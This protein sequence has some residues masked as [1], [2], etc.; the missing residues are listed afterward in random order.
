MGVLK[1]GA[2]KREITP[3]LGTDLFGYIRRF[4]SSSGVHDPLWASFL[5]VENGGRAV[6]LISLDVL[7]FSE[8]FATQAKAA[9]SEG[10]DVAKENI[11]VAA[12]HTHSAPGMHFFRNGGKRDKNWEYRLLA[13]LV[14]GSKEARQNSRK[15]LMGTGTGQALIGYNRRNS[16]KDID[17][18]LT[19]TCFT[20]E[21][22]QPF[23]FVANY[24]CHPVVLKE[25]NLLISADY[26]GYFRDQL[27]SMFSADIVTLFFSGAAGDVDPIKRGS[28]ALAEKLAGIL[29]KEARALIE[30]MHWE[31]SG[32][33]RIERINLVLPYEK[34]PTQE[35]AEKTYEEYH[36]LY[37][38]AL[39][40]GNRTAI[41]IQRALLLWADDLKKAVRGQKLADF[42]E[43]ELQCLKIG[44]SILLAF[45]FELFS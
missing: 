24:G 4:G 17:S 5:W 6:L 13:V 42:L 2:A 25:D 10:M 19:L 9:I 45:P 38:R 18:N 28:F 39:E 1:A 36:S 44:D 11:C 22:K 34:I 26:V 16:G 30:N 29:F 23:C 27:S 33:I 32:D 20:D 35:E 15:A 37:R 31:S 43:C 40:K 41:K 3:P 12:I 21:E 7:N 8:E 14:D